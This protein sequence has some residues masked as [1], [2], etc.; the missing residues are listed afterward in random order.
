MKERKLDSMS[1][2]TGL[3]SEAELGSRSYGLTHCVA[4]WVGQPHSLVLP[5]GIRAW[6]GRDITQG[7]Y[8]HVCPPCTCVHFQVFGCQA[9]SPGFLVKPASRFICLYSWSPGVAC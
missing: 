9:S 4:G 3:G 2:D 6:K 7:P 5:L 8:M 1:S